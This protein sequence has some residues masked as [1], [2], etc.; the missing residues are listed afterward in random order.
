MTS[1]FLNQGTG[2]AAGTVL[3]AA[4]TATPF[5][6]PLAIPIGNALGSLFGGIFGGSSSGGG[7]ATGMGKKTKDYLRTKQDYTLENL[8]E[9]YATQVQ[10]RETAIETYNYA[11]D[12]EFANALKEYEIY[13]DQ[14]DDGY[15]TQVD[16]YKDSVDTFDLTTELNSM[17]AQIAINDSARVYNERIIELGMQQQQLMMQQATF[18]AQTEISNQLIE[19]QMETSIMSASFNA[20]GIQASTE[21]NY[22]V[23]SFELEQQAFQTQADV[24][25]L[26]ADAE[27]TL[28]NAEIRQNDILRQL[29]QAISQADFAQQELILAREQTQADGAVQTDEARRQALLAEG[30]QI[31]K[32][33][34]GRS[35]QKSVQSIAFQSE[36][37]QALIASAITRADSK[38]LLDKSKIASELA[39][40]REQ[41]KSELSAA[42]VQLDQSAAGFGAAA[43]DFAARDAALLANEARIQGMFTMA[44]IDLEKT[45]L[46]LLSQ[47]KSLMSQLATNKVKAAEA[48]AMTSL[49]LS[50]IQ[51]AKDSAHREHL[52]QTDKINF[53]LYQANL[54]AAS[55]ILSEPVLPDLLPPPEYPPDLVLD[56]IPE[57][58]FKRLEK[59][60]N[61][62]IKAR[63]DT[64]YAGMAAPVIQEVAS[65][66]LSVADQIVKI[67]DSF[68]AP[69]NPLQPQTTNTFTDY[70]LDPSFTL[71]TQFA[72]TNY[73]N[74]AMSNPFTM[75]SN[76]D[77]SSGFNMA[78]DYTSSFVPSS[79]FSIGANSFTEATPFV[80]E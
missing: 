63:I 23:A 47:Q 27:A 49:S 10:G 1:S 19:S 17:S 21:T 43:L 25:R 5:A 34:A 32:G 42:A 24:I 15:N 29:D 3:G 31:A 66:V 7:G 44:G 57:I 39:F 54:G 22:N 46:N 60:G 28:A 14:R 52:V 59:I 77:F 38:Y 12:Q 36:Q 56:P 67:T 70:Y 69:T 76:M 20:F 40:A 72:S 62:G 11:R 74:T 78:P 80:I 9:Q 65:S 50:S 4:L 55:N 64:D 35:A 30:A 61:K 6:G 75:T 51:Y 53:D 68:K 73:M 2:G 13:L 48:A 8:A 71:P 58:D 37:V 18:D 16:L 41:G 79:D 33:Q 26:S 45:S